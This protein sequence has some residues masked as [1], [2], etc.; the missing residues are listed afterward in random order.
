MLALEMMTVGLLDSVTVKTLEGI[1]VGL[2]DKVTVKTLDGITV[3]LLDR[4]T[5][6]TL[7]SATVKALVLFWTVRTLRL[8]VPATDSML[9]MVDTVPLGAVGTPL[10]SV[11]VVT[12]VIA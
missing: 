11:T 6:A 1:T 7:D 12:F 2:L 9:S 4:V 8:G 5:V 3:G 10:L